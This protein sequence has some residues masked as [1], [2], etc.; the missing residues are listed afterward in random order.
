MNEL[1]CY[2]FH[3]GTSSHAY[4][5]LGAHYTK[6]ETTFRVWAPHA[7]F[8]SVI[9]DFN[10]WNL[11]L[12]GMKRITEEGIFEL[13]VKGVKE[14]DAYMFALTTYDNR[15]IYKSD[16][17]AFHSELRPLKNS[18]VFDLNNYEFH[19]EKWMKERKLSYSGFNKYKMPMNIYE[20]HLSSWIKYP[21]GNYYNYAS[22]ANELV[23]YLKKMNYT[24]VEIMPISEYPY[25]P[26]W[27]YQVTGFYSITSRYGTP[28]D[29][30]KFVDVLHQNNIGVII[31]W[32]P[33]HFNKDENGLIDFDGESLYEPSSEYKKEHKSWGTRCFDYGRCEIQSFLVSN[34]MFFFD[35]FHVDGLRMDAVSSM[36]YLDYGRND[37]EW[38]LNSYGN[39]INLEAIS[40]IKKVN[41]VIHEYDS[42]CLM[43]AEE[44]TSFPGIT[45][46]INEG[47]LGFDYKWNMGWM[48]DTLKFMETDPYWRGDHLNL[49]NFQLTYIFSEH[50][51][52]A[53]SH[54][55]VVH[56]K[57]SLLNKMP[58]SYEKKFSN[59]KTYFTYLLTHPGK[60]L[61]FMGSD[62]G[63]FDEW[64]E[65]RETNWGLLNYPSHNGLNNYLKD[66]NNLYLQNQS[67]HN[68]TTYWDG[69]HWIICD[70]R[71]H[72]VFCYERRIHNELLLCILN[73]ADYE[74]RDFDIYNL[75]DGDYQ[76]LICSEDIK[77]NGYYEVTK[78]EYIV[79]N[80]KLTITLPSCSGIILKRKY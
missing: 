66:I 75:V 3:Q 30:M 64:N 19:D 39:N 68:D 46:P 80:S 48:N 21:D 43:I 61:L 20:L 65:N 28:I 1:A 9:G 51:I 78:Q 7:K 71:E 5:F 16:P 29:F 74:W 72:A 37:G 76:L 52:L 60:K 77:Y 36:L 59:L 56:L 42:S 50:Y 73:F 6:E 38:Q 32:V 69:F 70:D 55:E 67:L 27:G 54:D 8:V 40:W 13:V 15:V 41:Q 79:T 47:G 44:S 45:K 12:G 62:I 4:D 11:N 33:G 22:F 18:K 57:K 35:K 2:Y 14:F 31:D 23:K 58:G 26:S 17:Y 49:I 53:L 10:N 24:H 25:D 63:E 34:A